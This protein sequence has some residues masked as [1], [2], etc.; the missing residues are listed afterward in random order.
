MN[1]TAGV[2]C[3]AIHTTDDVIVQ[4]VRSS[5]A[6]GQNVNKV[7]TKVDMRFNVR[8][9]PWLEDDVKEAVERTVRCEQ[10]CMGAFCG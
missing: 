10:H 4:F 8:K 6:G 7:S 3:D 2:A 1:A 5:G 9:A